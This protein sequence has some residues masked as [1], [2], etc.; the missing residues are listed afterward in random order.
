MDPRPV[1]SEPQGLQRRN[2]GVFQALYVAR[3]CSQVR[4]TA[5]EEDLVTVPQAPAGL[6]TG[7]SRALPPPSPFRLVTNLFPPAA[8]ALL[9]ARDLILC[10]AHLPP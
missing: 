4:T 9:K 8:H 3:M 1:V 2:W 5:L 7:S 10:A 6:H